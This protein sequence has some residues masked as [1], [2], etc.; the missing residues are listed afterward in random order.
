[1]EFSETPI[2]V[3]VY[4]LLLLLL[5]CPPSP[6]APNDLAAVKTVVV[7]IQALVG[8]TDQDQTQATQ[9]HGTVLPLLTGTKTAQPGA[10]AP[11]A[12]VDE[13]LGQIER[14]L[15]GNLKAGVVQGA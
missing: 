2:N 13:C 7:E 10:A 3:S 9:Q 15:A 6:S 1:M 14:I 11:M 8:D 5:L 4:L 12:Y